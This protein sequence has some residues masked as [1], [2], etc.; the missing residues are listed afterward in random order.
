MLTAT[1]RSKSKYNTHLVYTVQRT[2]RPHF[3]HR[4]VDPNIYEILF[5]QRWELQNYGMFGG[6]QHVTRSL[7]YSCPSPQGKKVRTLGFTL[8][9]VPSNVF[10]VP[11]STVN[12]FDGTDPKVDKMK[13]NIRNTIFFPC[14]HCCMSIIRQHMHMYTYAAGSTEFNNSAACHVQGEPNHLHL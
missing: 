9:S 7:R 6:S 2:R 14:A 10:K 12:K 8:G 5:L 3:H 11:K 13:P 4:Q 1:A